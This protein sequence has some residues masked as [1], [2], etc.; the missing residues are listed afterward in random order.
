MCS[1]PLR[2]GRTLALAPPNQPNQEQ[3]LNMSQT[4]DQRRERFKKRVRE[5]LGVVVEEALEMLDAAAD[6]M[7]KRCARFFSLPRYRAIVQAI[8]YLQMV[9]RSQR[10]NPPPPHDPTLPPGGC[11]E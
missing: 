5:Q 11:F 2:G 1:L 9:T 4:E 10:S 6:Q 3:S 8:L 7:G